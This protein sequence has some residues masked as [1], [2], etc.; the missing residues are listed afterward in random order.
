[1][2][3]KALEGDRL[4]QIIFKHYGTLKVYTEVLESNTHLINKVV[5]KENDIVQLPLIN[6]V[7]NPIEE[8]QKLW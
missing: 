5:L 4:D 3:H 6:I 1:M 7:E 2:T 8:V